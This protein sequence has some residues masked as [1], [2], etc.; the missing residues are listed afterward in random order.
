[1]NKQVRIE[2]SVDFLPQ[3]EVDEYFSMRPK[4]SQLGSFVSDQSQVID[5]RE[6]LIQRYNKMEEKYA[7]VASIPT[8]DNW[9][10]IRVIPSSFEFWQ[11]QSSRLHDRIVFRRKECRNE[12]NEIVSNRDVDGG[13]HGQKVHTATAVDDGVEGGQDLWIMERLQP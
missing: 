6:A 7:D 11:G 3:S 12:C 8:P 4:K 10:G 2:G 9:G 5:S 1:M 13:I